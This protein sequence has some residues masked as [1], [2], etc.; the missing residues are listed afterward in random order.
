[1]D[2]CSASPALQDFRA[3]RGIG[4]SARLGVR[5]AP[6][7]TDPKTSAPIYSWTA[8]ADSG[9]DSLEIEGFG[10]DRRKVNVRLTTR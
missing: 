2:V 7:V 9:K 6:R 1:L 4:R 5:L 8:D 10:A 3:G